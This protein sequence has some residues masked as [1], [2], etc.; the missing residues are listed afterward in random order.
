MFCEFSS[1]EFKL[2][3]QTADETDPVLLVLLASV[4]IS[5]SLLLKISHRPSFPSVRV[6]DGLLV[7]F[8]FDKIFENTSLP[9]TL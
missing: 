4:R 3:T 5:D 7:S 8:S 1:G 9:H 2:A 6:S